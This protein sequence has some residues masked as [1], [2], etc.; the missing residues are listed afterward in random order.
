MLMVH[1][2]AVF[3]GSST[4]TLDMKVCRTLLIGPQPIL[5]VCRFDHSPCDPTVTLKGGSTEQFACVACGLQFHTMDEWNT[6]L[7]SKVSISLLQSGRRL[8][9]TFIQSNTWVGI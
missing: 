2:A 6:H 8:A 7:Q 3:Q 5:C 1:I 9:D 4:L